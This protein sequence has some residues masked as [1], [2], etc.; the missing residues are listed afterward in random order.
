LISLGL[1][2]LSRDVVVHALEPGRLVAAEVELGARGLFRFLAEGRLQLPPS[3]L[4]R[5]ALDRA[6]VL[7]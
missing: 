2:T 1:R 5:R 6:L 3:A 7:A 4:A